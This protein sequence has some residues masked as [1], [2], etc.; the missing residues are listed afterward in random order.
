MQIIILYINLNN[1]QH[2][3]VSEPSLKIA[4]TILNHEI[5]SQN[6]I[7]PRSHRPFWEAH[8]PHILSIS[9]PHLVCL[10]NFYLLR[11][12]RLC[13]EIAADVSGEMHASRRDVV[14]TWR[15]K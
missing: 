5:I 9:T 12:H 8:V 6:S 4:I 10:H 7:R 11:I 3:H 15:Y 2:T 13:S 14:G 1:L